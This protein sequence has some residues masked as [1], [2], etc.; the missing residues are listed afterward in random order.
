MK[1]M[2]KIED[3]KAKDPFDRVVL[4]KNMD[5]AILTSIRT[6]SK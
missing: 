1:E 6:L 5:N 4:T 3:A 2:I